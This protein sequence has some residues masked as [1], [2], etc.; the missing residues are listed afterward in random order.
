MSKQKPKSYKKDNREK[1]QLRSRER[2]AAGRMSMLGQV[3][4]VFGGLLTILTVP[5]S[6]LCPWWCWFVGNSFFVGA[7]L[8]HFRIYADL[9][10]SKIMRQPFRQRLITTD[11]FK[12][13]RHPM[14]TLVVLGALC[15]LLPYQWHS[16]RVVLKLLL[17]MATTAL[18]CY[19][20]ELEVLVNFGDEA[21]RYYEKTPR[22]FFMYPFMRKRKES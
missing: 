3:L 12:F 15:I 6:P 14:Y 17:F 9:Y 16:P 20:H 13:T 19:F 22:L 7:I 21:K 4:W 5:A 1:R 18:A 2:V 10:L 8:C 11:I